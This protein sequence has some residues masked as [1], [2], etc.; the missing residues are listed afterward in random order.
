M[1][2]ANHTVQPDLRPLSGSR[3]MSVCLLSTP[4]S[5]IQEKHSAKPCKVDTKRKSGL[6]GFTRSDCIDYFGRCIL[7]VN[8]GVRANPSISHKTTDNVPVQR[9]RMYYLIH[10]T[11]LSSP[12]RLTL[13]LADT[14]RISR[15]YS[16][17]MAPQFLLLASH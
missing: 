10:V 17:Q 7:S 12:R 8:A 9:I 6:A 13:S 4:K 1:T 3:C 5:H 16:R 11:S 15:V 2:P 14:V